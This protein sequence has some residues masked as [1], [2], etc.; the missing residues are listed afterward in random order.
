VLRRATR[1]IG[2]GSAALRAYCE[3]GAAGD[4]LS[5]LP[6][7]CDVD[8]FTRVAADQIERVR[9]RYHLVGK[10]VFLFSGQMIERKGIDVLLRAFERVAERY[11]NV[12]LLL[13]GDGPG[14]GDYE[15]SVPEQVRD[16]VHFAGLL[17]QQDLPAHFAAAD[18]FVFP[19]R[20][21]GWGV[22]LNEAC[23]SRLP[24]IASRQTGAALDLVEET[25]NGF[26][27]DCEDVEGFA[28]KMQFFVEHVDQIEPFGQRSWELVQPFSAPQGAQR[29]RDCVL[30]TIGAGV[31]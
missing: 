17:S 18:V 16:R 3:M 31:R 5:L 29:F 28:T 24:I 23:G 27:L 11:A 6:Y 1:V 2:M 14:K 4:R 8:R 30:E 20:H 25:G 26:L 9:N 7:C 12:A 13:L 21:D 19:S 10:T 22:V 15:K